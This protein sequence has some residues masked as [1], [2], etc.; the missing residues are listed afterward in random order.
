MPEY[1]DFIANGENYITAGDQFRVSGSG[2][3]THFP[4]IFY[5]TSSERHALDKQL[6]N[7]QTVNGVLRDGTSVL[8]PIIVIEYMSVPSFNYAYIEKFKRY[9][10]VTD[11]G[12]VVNNIWS[13]SLDVDVLMS[14]GTQIRNCSAMVERNEYYYYLHVIDTHRQP[15]TEVIYVDR[16]NGYRT[17]DPTGLTDYSYN[18]V[19]NISSTGTG[20]LTHDPYPDISPLVRAK[21]SDMIRTSYLYAFAKY[22]LDGLMRYVYS[23]SFWDTV[24]K[25]FAN[26]SDAIISLIGYPMD[27][28]AHDTGGGVLGPGVARYADHESLG[29]EAYYINGSYDCV[30]NL[31]TLNTSSVYNDWRDYPPAARWRIFLPYCGWF[32]VDPNKLAHGAKIQ[33]IVELTTGKCKAVVSK[34]RSTRDQIILTADGQIGYSIPISSTNLESVMRNDAQILGNMLTG[35]IA[36]LAMGNPAG[37]VMAGAGGLMSSLNNTLS[38]RGVAGTGIM[39]RFL[40]YE[41]RLVI[42]QQLYTDEG[43]NYAHLEGRPLHETVGLS[44]LSG[45]TVCSSVDLAGV[46]ATKPELD[47]IETDLKGGV[48]L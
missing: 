14:F 47:Q 21:M 38:F 17:F 10:Y 31:G 19:L 43:T 16:P 9:Y 2:T 40:P 25:L 34:L 4:I 30:W 32:D 46:T 28:K 23:S 20:I 41:P 22:E 24:T 12:S 45:F 11:V 13:I 39:G 3:G 44:S 42:E 37:A 1:L 36:S 29:F 5:N 15:T 8:H 48:I 27:I 33:Y 18:Y 26:P 6:T 7:P 35:Q